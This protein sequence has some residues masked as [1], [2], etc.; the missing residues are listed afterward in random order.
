MKIEKI[1]WNCGEL[2]VGGRSDKKYCSSKCRSAYNNRQNYDPFK[3]HLKLAKGFYWNLQVL[4]RII[5][6]HPNK[7]SFTYSELESW[8]FNPLGPFF[9]Y[10][11][12]SKT[13]FKVGPYYLEKIGNRFTLY[14]EPP[15]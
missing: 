9:I 10:W 5:E 11:S 14:K 13:Y 6:H 12:N 2:V 1:C 3:S 4:N 8:N 7:L 15:L